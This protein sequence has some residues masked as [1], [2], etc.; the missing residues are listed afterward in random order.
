M[1]RLIF[2]A[3]YYKPNERTSRGGMAKYIAT[4]EGVEIL[5]SGMAEYI[6]ARH[7]SHGLFSDEGEEIHLS[8]VAEE[9]DHHTGNV[10]GL[11]FSLQREDAEA[12]GYNSATQWM[13]LLR[14]RR[15]DIARAMHISPAN[16]RWYAAYHNAETHPHVH[17]LVWSTD[18]T[19]PYLGVNGIHEIKQTLSGDIFRQEL[20][21]VYKEQTTVREELKEKFRTRITELSDELAHGNFSFSSDLLQMMMDLSRRLDKHKGKKVYGY[22][23]RHTKKQVDEIVKRIAQDEKISALYD[24]WYGYKCETV[25]T[26]TDVMPEKIPLEENEEFKSLRNQV[27]KVAASLGELFELPACEILDEDGDEFD[28]ESLKRL[29]FLAQYK[30]EPAAQYHYGKYLYEH[31]DD[32]EDAEYYLKRSAEKGNLSAAYLLYKGYHDGRFTS[33]PMEKMNYLR[34]AANGG[35]GYAAYEFAKLL[36]DS[37]LDLAKFYLR[38]AA[39][40]GVAYAAYRMGVMLTK[41]GNR[42]E[43]RTYFDTAATHD[44]Q[45]KTRVGVMYCYTFHDRE[46]GEELLREASENGYTPATDVLHALQSEMDARII[47]G[48]CNLFYYAGSCIRNEH[49]DNRPRPVRNTIDRKEMQQIMRKKMA[50]GLKL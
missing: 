33:E 19:E 18:P 34:M 15:N 3:P 49:E 32:M 21:S 40:K 25:R 38:L 35:H 39:D 22:L 16:L 45:M 29:E 7:G 37:N 17:M 14:S 12:L 48:L 4:R 10:W 1:A 5:R 26:Y 6:G 11:I 43:A 30:E 9:I 44:D 27:V 2:K 24:A 20:Y 46:S 41:E 50:H 13:N 42:E 28:E 23:D 47:L 36:T 8:R 31:D